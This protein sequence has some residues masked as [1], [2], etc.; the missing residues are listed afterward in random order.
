M[1]SQITPVIL[2]YNEAPNIGRTLEALRWARAVVVVDSRS[3]D[4]TTAIARSFPN[5][6]MFERPFDDHATQWNFAVS[7]TGIATPWI[8]ALDAD[9]VL[10]PELVE[11]LRALEPPADVAAYRTAFTYWVFGSPLRGSAYPPVVTLFRAGRGR[12]RQDG[13]TQRIAVDGEIRDLVH[14]IRHDDRKP[15]RR[16]MAAQLRY[17]RL[18]AAKLL[19]TPLAQLDT[20]DR[21]RRLVVIAPIVMPPYCLFV[22]GN[23][24]DGV[25]GLYYAAQRTVAE[26]LL[27]ARLVARMLRL[28]SRA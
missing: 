21:L 3:S 13:H 17:S 11:E 6:R 8:L 27:S 15:F 4:A 19:A 20:A 12:Y 28:Q 10:P 24:L 14:R 2:T 23:A 7:Q 16:W 18:E 25:G 9:Y 1:L 26:L 5:V 22:K